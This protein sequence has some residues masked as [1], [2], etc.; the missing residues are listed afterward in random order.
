MGILSFSGKD[1]A[2]RSAMQLCYMR[3]HKVERIINYNMVIGE[4][5]QHDVA[6]RQ[7]GVYE[8][9]KT[10]LR[11]NDIII[12]C[13][14]DIVDKKNHII[15][16]VKNID[17]NRPL[18]DWYFKNSIVQCVLYSTVCHFN[19]NVFITPIFRIK[20]GFK[21]DGFFLTN[22]EYHLLFGEEEYNIIA[23]DYDAILL[24]FSVKA[25]SSKD[26]ESAKIFDEFHKFKHFEDLR[27]YFDYQLIKNI[28]I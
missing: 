12:S 1:L 26:Y 10:V 2:T 16:E 3:N 15:T 4:Q 28:K 7:K 20:Q 5:H 18:E 17:P 13:C 8:E 25:N 24:Y 23:K 27:K 11:Y 9:M 19:G 22:I 21:Q 6:Q 14:H